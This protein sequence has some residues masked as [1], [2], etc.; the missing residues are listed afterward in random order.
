[1][2]NILYNYIFFVFIIYF[3]LK[4][5]KHYF[6]YDNLVY[7]SSL[8][9]HLSITLIYIN[10]FTT[11][12]WDNYIQVPFIGINYGEFTTASFFS[13][14]LVKSFSFFLSKLLFLNAV[15][16]I[17]VF[18]L[19]SFFGI[20]LFVNN[21]IKLGFEKKLAY[22]LLFIPSLHFWTGIPG[23]DSLILLFL[24]FFFH[25]YIDRKIFL[26]LFFLFLVFLIRPHIGLIFFVSLIIA[27]FISLK[28]FYKKLSILFF[29][30]ITFYLIL[31]AERTRGFFL[32]SENVLSDNFFLKIAN[33]LVN[34]AQK[35][36]LSN[37]TYDAGNI[38][39]NI[40]AYVLF[41]LDFILKPNSIFIDILIIAEIICLIFII[42]LI[43]KN[44][45]I[46]II[47]NRLIYFLS[48]C[49]LLY[50]FILPQVFF[51]Y[52][53]NVRQKWMILPFLIYYSF[54]L[55]NLFVKINKI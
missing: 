28:G 7:V 18:S 37:S 12:D 26:S 40:F 15:N 31:T 1:M 55:K 34:I 35:Y 5:N 27:E 17:L 4:I 30:C 24:S 33:Q 9:F 42:F 48:T 32:K 19:I 20:I 21:L 23:K 8:F 11:G 22:F 52:G 6:N 29:S 44:S 2:L 49:L 53:I 3:T 41:P 54:L 13:S 38:L 14:T 51:N 39:S 43:L 45:K 25:F 36:G 10:V 46:S 50:L 47:D 16:E